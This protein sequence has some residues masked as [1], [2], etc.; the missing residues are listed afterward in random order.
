M[1]FQ[2]KIV[3]MSW[4]FNWQFNNQ[5]LT[6]EQSSSVTITIENNTNSTLYFSDFNIKFDN[7]IIS[8]SQT[9]IHLLPNQTK[10]C[11]SE[12][13][14]IPA[15]IVGKIFFYINFKVFQCIR[16]NWVSLGEFNSSSGYYIPI[17]HQPIYTAFVSKGRSIMDR[18]VGDP[19]SQMLMEW[20]FSTRTVGFEVIVNDDETPEAVRREIKNSDAIILIATQRYLDS[21]GAKKVFEWAYSEIGIGYAHKKPLVII[22]ETG[23]KIGGLSSYLTKYGKVLEIPFYRNDL[24][25]LRHILGNVMPLFRNNIKDNKWDDFVE[26][27]L[28]FIAKAAVGAIAVTLFNGMSRSFNPYFKP[29]GKQRKRSKQIKKITKR[30]T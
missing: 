21:E 16:K 8:L 7:Y 27:G 29:K 12:Q 20:G 26:R 2:L 13:F 24:E 3:I 22:K 1:G 28:D 11:A 23:V 4:R 10:S 18:E 15:N 25:S 19:I 6:P 30:S 14:S 9:F 17:V 5:M